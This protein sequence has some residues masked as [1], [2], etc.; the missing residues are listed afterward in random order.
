L[1][2]APGDTEHWHV[3]GQAGTV[4]RFADDSAVQNA[5]LVLDVG[6]RV[7]SGGE[8]GLL[9]MAFD[10]DFATTGRLYLSYTRPGPT[11]A[12]PISVISRWF[13]GDGGETIAADSEVV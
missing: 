12:R 5:E 10:P 2:R 1:L 11:S 8:Q 13:S 7:V 9:G 3:V 4:H 6:D